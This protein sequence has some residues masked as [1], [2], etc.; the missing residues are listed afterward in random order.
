MASRQ[1]ESTS[2]VLGPQCFGIDNAALR[3]L[4][5]YFLDLTQCPRIR[6]QIERVL[7]RCEIAGAKAGLKPFGYA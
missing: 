1:L 4:L 6:Q 2:E 5:A 3:D 7:K